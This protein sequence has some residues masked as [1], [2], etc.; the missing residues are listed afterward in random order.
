MSTKALE[1][2]KARRHD[3]LRLSQGDR[4]FSKRRCRAARAALGARGV[5]TF[6]CLAPRA[7]RAKPLGLAL[8]PGRLEHWVRPPA[9][10][11]DS[12]VAEGRCC[13]GPR[14]AGHGPEQWHVAPE[15][16]NARG[17]GH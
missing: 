11:R 9:R 14:P 17:A 16:V 7:N 10:S 1:T 4:Q 2:K 8:L 15:S 12:A 6:G 3:V 13:P 5:P